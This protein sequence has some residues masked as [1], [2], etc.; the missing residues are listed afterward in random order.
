[1]AIDDSIRFL[2]GAHWIPIDN[3]T[4]GSKEFPADQP[5]FFSCLKLRFFLA[6]AFF[7]IKL[8]NLLEN[9]NPFKN[10]QTKATS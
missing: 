8:L 2:G 5:C 6:L 9:Q 10:K 4:K 3:S 7:R 1:M